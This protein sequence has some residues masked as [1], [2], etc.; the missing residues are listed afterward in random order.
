MKRRQQLETNDAGIAGH[1]TSVAEI[2][3]QL[4]KLG[5]LERYQ[6]LSALGQREERGGGSEKIFIQWIKELGVHR[7][8]HEGKGKLRY[9]PPFQWEIFN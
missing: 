8:T 1:A 4:S 7:T 6:Q 9:A 5:G 2:D 3:Q